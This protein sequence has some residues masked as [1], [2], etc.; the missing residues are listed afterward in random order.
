M[1]WPVVSIIWLNYNSAK[2]IDIVLKSLEASVDLDYPSNK[3]ELIVVDNGSNDGSFEIIKDFLNKKFSLRKKI[4]K[5]ERNL[6]FTGGNNVGFR[7]RDL[8]SKYVALLN[9]DAIPLPESLQVLVEYAEARDDVGAVQGIILDMDT[10]RIDTAGDMLTELLGA[11]QLYHGQV[12]QSVKKSFYI[13]Y[14]DG[15]YFLFKVNAVKK[16]TGFSDKIFYDEM[17]AYFDDSILGLQLWNRGFKIVSY[18]SLTAF[19]RRS[20]SFGKISPLKI[21]LMTRGY[22][23]LNELCNSRYKKLIRKSFY[24]RIMRMY[25]A[26]LLASKIVGG[27][28]RLQSPPGELL[29]A[30]YRGYLDGLRWGRRKIEELG[31]SIDIYK[32]PILRTLPQEATTMLLTGIGID[33]F[34][35]YYTESIGRKFE[36]KIHMFIAD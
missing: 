36:R 5:L 24:T 15:A 30:F 20:S 3:F 6:G 9:N 1:V 31:A 11:Y 19:H 25:M 27:K 10:G 29:H 28:Y 22:I 26:R 21:Y 16:A 13:S 35:R 14:A 17:F 12:H 8:D 32:A 33:F 7:A 18:P 4:I 2:I 34:R 23:A